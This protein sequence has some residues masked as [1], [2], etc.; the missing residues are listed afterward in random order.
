MEN[1]LV[2]PAYDFAGN[3]KV[4]KEVSIHWLVQKNDKDLKYLV[5]IE[6]Q[7][8]DSF[9]QTRFGFFTTED[10]FKLISL[11]ARKRL[12]LLDCENIAR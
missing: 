5:D 9:N 6:L 12:I 7:L 3:L 1:T 8:V 11:E 4:I 2:S 10:K